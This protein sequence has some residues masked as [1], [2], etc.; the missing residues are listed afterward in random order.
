MALH[1]VKVAD[2]AGRLK[3]VAV[4][5]DRFMTLYRFAQR[6]PGHF[7]GDASDWSGMVGRRP[8]AH[9]A[10]EALV[11]SVSQLAYVEA[12]FYDR[13]YRPMQYD[14]L[15]PLDYSAGEQAATIEY[16]I[17]D[18]V[19][20]AQ[21]MDS[22]ADD[23]PYV[24]VAMAR[25]SFPVVHAGIGYQFTQQEL[26]TSA[27][28]KRPLPTA[29]M[30][31][32]M[33]AFQRKLN[34]VGLLGNT[35]K[36]ITGLLN[37]AT[38]AHTT[39]PSGKKWDGSDATPITSAQLFSDFNYGMNQVW[40][41]SGYNVIPNFVGVPPLAYAYMANTPASATIPTITILDYLLEHNLCN[42]KR[43]EQLTIEPVYDAAT[44]GVGP[45]GRVV[46]YDK[47]DQTLTMHVPM[48]LRFLAPQLEGVK[49]RVP[50]EFRYSGVEIRRITNVQ[51]LDGAQ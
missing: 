40:T 44:A 35:G 16:E 22:A 8:S 38:V 18:K 29:R 36:N 14:K 30:G 10:T 25:K 1:T 24:D 21:D 50:G 32:A 9:D 51:Y 39:T 27:V 15:L 28:F 42:S 26:R 31:A 48:P 33:E 43:G 23:V 49:V 47:T 12:G 34:Y 3:M 17:Y 20:N 7:I 46:F 45:S 5:E 41:N 13:Y 4:D 6:N 11:F 37:N 2:D 19:G